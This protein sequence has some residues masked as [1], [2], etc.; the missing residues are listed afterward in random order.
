MAE[1]VVFGQSFKTKKALEEKLRSMLHT[2]PLGVEFDE[3]E[4][5]FLLCVLF[6]HPDVLKKIGRGVKAFRV[7]TSEYKNRC[8]EVVRVDGTYEEFSYPR[9]ARGEADEHG[10]PEGDAAME[11]GGDSPSHGSA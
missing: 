10:Q 3:P 6:R 1:I 2:A 11:L 9:C 5:S 4:H 8:F 7:T